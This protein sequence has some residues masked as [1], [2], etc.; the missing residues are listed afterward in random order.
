M[1]KYEKGELSLKSA[2]SAF[3]RVKD[4]WWER[5]NRTLHVIIRTFETERQTNPTPALLP[6]VQAM[7]DFLGFKYVN[8]YNVG[9]KKWHLVFETDEPKVVVGFL[10]EWEDSCIKTLRKYGLLQAKGEPSNG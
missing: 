1:L 4:Y 6:I 5:K 7:G 8:A 10:L 2:L 9:F 3:F